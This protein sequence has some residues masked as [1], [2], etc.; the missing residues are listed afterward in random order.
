VR[1]CDNEERPKQNLRE[2]GEQ[3]KIFFEKKNGRESF[4][5]KTDIGKKTRERERDLES[6]MRA[7]FNI[8]FFL[9]YLHFRAIGLVAFAI[10]RP[11]DVV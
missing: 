1:A 3:K 8:L 2:K 5:K 4:L 7:S 9:L 11:I 10:A 6:R